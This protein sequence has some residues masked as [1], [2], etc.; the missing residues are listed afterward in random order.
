L[1]LPTGLGECGNN[2]W[3]RTR[4]I[5]TALGAGLLLGL[6]VLFAVL[7]ALAQP[8][9][10]ATVAQAAAPAASAATAVTIEL[11][12]DQRI[13]SLDGR[14]RYWVDP[15]GAATAD[16][17]DAAADTLPLATRS[18]GLSL[19][20]DGKALW[21]QFDVAKQRG[22]RW[23]VEVQSSGIDRV[24]MFYRNAEG[25]WVVQEAG[26]TKAVSDWPIPGRFPTFELSPVSNQPGA[27]RHWL[28]IEHARVD[29]ATPIVLSSQAALVASREREQFLLGGYFGLALLIAAV[30]AANA[31]AYRDRNFGTYAVYVA[32]LALGQL[33]YLGVG[34]QRLWVHWLKWNEISTFLLPGVSAAAALWFARTVTEPAR[35]S[36]ALDVVVWGMIAALLGAVA[37]DTA[38]ATRASLALLMLLIMVALFLVVGLIVLVWRQGDDPHIRLI[39]LGFLPVLVA[40]V[41]PVL[42]GLNLIPASAL[43][44]Y[45]LSVGAAVEMPI[46][47][48]ALSLRG[49]LRRESQARAAALSG[50]DALTGLAD[51]RTLTSRL[52]SALKR[53][54]SLKHPCAMLAVRLTNLDAVA[55]EFGREVGERMLVV[56]ASLL[57]NTITDIDMAARVA[58]CDFAL[59]LEGPTTTENATS[60]AQQ[61]VASGL[62]NHAALPGSTILK[63]NIAV[64]LLPEGGLDAAGSRRWLLDSLNAIPLDARKPI[65][66]VN[67]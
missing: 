2:L 35:F 60:R 14:S 27:I 41:F 6:L 53:A 38:V 34:A 39:A 42:R 13:I 45:A 56:A 47:F 51:T 11:T 26:D 62:R 22:A 17:V 12:P 67:F 37:L 55:A 43:T 31:M 30:A 48:Y 36:R 3:V 50:H 57:R 23:Y 52:D 9:S 21:V 16:Q 28:R 7:A 1:F 32:A 18:P 63:F 46:L 15:A 65:R 64:A 33:A 44:R 40:A 25:R 20:L 58:E 8:G 54:R 19:D 29:F 49:S 24:Q 61:L 10:R 59:L 4:R 5:F 66:S